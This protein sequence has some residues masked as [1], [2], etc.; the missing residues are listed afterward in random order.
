MGIG[1]PSIHVN[2]GMDGS[3]ATHV[4]KLIARE[5]KTA[6]FEGAG[7]WGRCR[8]PLTSDQIMAIQTA[9]VVI[10]RYASRRLYHAGAAAYL[11]LD[12]IAAMVEDGEDVLVLEAE[13][14]EDITASILQPIIS[15][16]APHG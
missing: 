14:G 9:P 10:K 7:P 4:T 16:R 1:A 15:Q 8:G 11:A 3:V 5:T 12:D 2:A 6:Y 13:T